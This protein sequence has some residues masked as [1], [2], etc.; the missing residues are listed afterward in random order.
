M[1]LNDSF[2]LCPVSRDNSVGIQFFQNAAKCANNVFLCAEKRKFIVNS[3]AI[4]IYHV[5][6]SKASCAWFL[7]KKKQIY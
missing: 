7:Q 2:H 3:Q 6:I 5:V 1:L 4:S